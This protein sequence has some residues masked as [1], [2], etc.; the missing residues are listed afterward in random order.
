[1]ENKNKNKNVVLESGKK[2]VKLTC[3]KTT[4]SCF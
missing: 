3:E 2:M 4:D 1:M